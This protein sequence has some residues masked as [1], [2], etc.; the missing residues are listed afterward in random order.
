[1]WYLNL[2]KSRTCVSLFVVFCVQVVG[3]LHYRHHFIERF[4]LNFLLH[5]VQSHYSLRN[6]HHQNH[7]IQDRLYWFLRFLLFIW[8]LDQVDWESIEVLGYLQD[9]LHPLLH[10]R[11]PKWSYFHLYHVHQELT[12]REVCRTLYYGNLLFHTPSFRLNLTILST[13][14]LSNIWFD[15]EC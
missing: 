6:R 8:F 7:L 15:R 5:P 13:S 14:S 1:M 10:S 9:Q 12:V 4:L 3:C 2:D 11:L